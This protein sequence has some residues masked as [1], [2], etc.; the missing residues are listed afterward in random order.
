M[1]QYCPESPDPLGTH[2]NCG[3]CDIHGML[4]VG[5]SQLLDIPMLEHLGVPS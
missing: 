2:G 3:S 5:F 4:K 1:C